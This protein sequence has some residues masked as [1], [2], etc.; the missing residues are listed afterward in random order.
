M[1]L[2]SRGQIR[3]EVERARDEHRGILPRAR[4]RGDRVVDRLDL[5]EP[6]SRAGSRARRRAA[7]WRST[8]WSPRSVRRRA[9]GA[10][11]SPPRPCRG[12][13]TRRR[14][15]CPPGDAAA[16]SRARPGCA[17]RP[18]SPSRSDARAGPG[19][20]TSTSPSTPAPRNAPAASRAP[21][22]RTCL[23]GTSWANSAS[24]MTTIASCCGDGELLARDRLARLAEHVHVVQPD[25][26]EQD[27]RCVEHVRRVVASTE[28]RLDD[29][30]V[31]VVRREHGERRSG[32][33]LEL[34]RADRDR[35]LAYAADRSL[36]VGLGRHRSGSARSSRA[37]GARD[38]R[39]RSGPSR[40]GAPRSFAS[41]STCR[42][43]R[44]RGSRDSAGAGRRARRAASASA[45]GRTLPA[46]G[47]V[48]RPSQRPTA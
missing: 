9:P 14:C 18:R 39:R 3:E 43:S 42:S 48:T 32:Q 31:D 1:Q 30:S 19:A 23:P 36:E 15:S 6:P 45:P 7:P 13:S 26:R 17:R 24:G 12:G 27:D 29:R 40:R 16:P 20:R 2:L 41:P 44:R 10:R 4:D 38:T 47:R 11:A 28:P 8:R 46:R 5:G 21:P 22:S 33:H 37:R 25:V 34:R 35:G